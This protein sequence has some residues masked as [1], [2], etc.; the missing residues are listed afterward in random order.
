MRRYA[1][2]GIA[3]LVALLMAVA[4]E[5]RPAPTGAPGTKPSESP[6]EVALVGQPTLVMAP[7]TPDD[8]RAKE[9]VRVQN[10]VQTRPTVVSVLPTP[11]P[12]PTPSPT[13]T[14]TPGPTPDGVFRRARVPIVM[15]HHIDDPPAS[16]GRI[17]YNL[18]TPPS[19]FEDQLRMLKEQGYNVITLDDLVYYLTRGRP[20]PPKP[21]ILT[22][23]DGYVDNYTQAF[24]LLKKYGFVGT[25]F[26]ITDVVNQKHPD[27]L[28]WDMVR[29]MR[30]AGMRF[31]AHGRTHI[32]LSQADHDQLVWQALGSTEVFQAELGE[33]AR[34]IAYPSGRYNQQVIDIYKSAHYWA[35]LTTKQGVMQDS[36]H[37]FELKRI[38]VYHDTTGAQLKALL[39]MDWGEEEGEND[40]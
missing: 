23:D 38:R 32:D 28:T 9:C 6:T 34:Y 24:P 37:L 29:E 33:P 4:L 13:W 8:A 3:L 27:Y 35:G 5:A 17:R 26:I 40:R 30:D 12:S 7:S 25:F 15:Y 21:V 1:W 31:G 22:F 2:P 18:S 16:V 10:W 20:L 39:E 11:T 19:L 36:D 14:P